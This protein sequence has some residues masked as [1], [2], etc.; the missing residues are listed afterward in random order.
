MYMYIHIYNMYIH[1]YIYIYICVCACLMEWLLRPQRLVVSLFVCYCPCIVMSC[2]CRE[3]I[4]F[5]LDVLVFLI[6]PRGTHPHFFDS[7][8]NIFWDLYIYTYIYFFFNV[9]ETLFQSDFVPT[10]S[11]ILSNNDFAT[12]FQQRFCNSIPTI[13]LQPYSNKNFATIRTMILQL[14]SQQCFCHSIHTPILHQ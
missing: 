9:R 10:A 14:Y 7:T 8:L 13:I 5:G 1:I 2:V 11:R 4:C 12:L 3:V 6:A